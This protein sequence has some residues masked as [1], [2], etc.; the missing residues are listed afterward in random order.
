MQKRA[1]LNLGMKCGVAVELLPHILYFRSA[2]P[3]KA[4]EIART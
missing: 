1:L 4:K 3:K 2:T